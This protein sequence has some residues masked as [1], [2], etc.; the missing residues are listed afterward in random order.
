MAAL[1]VFVIAC[2]AVLGA[3]QV[4][5]APMEVSL[6]EFESLSPNSLVFMEHSL[7]TSIWSC[8][9]QATPEITGLI[10]DVTLL[11]LTI[12]GRISNLVGTIKGCLNTESSILCISQAIRD[13][14]D[15]SEETRDKLI[16]L[17]VRF[18]Q[19]VKDFK[20]C[21]ANGEPATTVAPDTTTALPETTAADVETTAADLETTADDLETTADD[22]E[23]TADD[24]ETTAD[25]LETTADEF[26]MDI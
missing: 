25:D 15:N 23:T 10:K 17:I 19:L 8:A 12:Q 13:E 5:S 7:R 26:D 20:K 6:M 3:S 22:L 16:D 24:L 18:Q 21:K 9:L 4:A 11:G 1:R 2:I 14:Y